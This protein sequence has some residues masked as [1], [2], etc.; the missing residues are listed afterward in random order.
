MPRQGWNL[1]LAGNQSNG[2]AARVQNA[3][4][5]QDASRVNHEVIIPQ[6]DRAIYGLGVADAAIVIRVSDA[7]KRHR[8][9]LEVIP[10]GWNPSEATRK[11]AHP[12][13]RGRW[14]GKPSQDG[15]GIG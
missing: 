6:P 10:T 3:R 11:L 2:R 7:R 5:R 15:I 4:A 8:L 14:L 12:G 13:K 9:R 1:R